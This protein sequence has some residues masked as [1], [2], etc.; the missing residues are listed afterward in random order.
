LLACLLA[1]LLRVIAASVASKELNLSH[2]PYLKN[3]IFYVSSQENFITFKP[4]L[5]FTTSSD[6]RFKQKHEAMATR[7]ASS[8]SIN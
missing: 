1:S 3:V 2:V 6:V 5:T 8:S 4:K 7:A